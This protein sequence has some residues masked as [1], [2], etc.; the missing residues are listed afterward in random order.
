[1]LL[2]YLVKFNDTKNTKVEFEI[3][4]KIEFLL[5]TVIAL[6]IGLDYFLKRKHKDTSK[7]I[8][9][10]V[11]SKSKPIKKY[12]K[13]KW[14]L[15]SI[16]VIAV[17]SFLLYQFKFAP[18]TY[19]SA[20]VV[21]NDNLAYLKSD[22]SLFNGKI[23]DSLARGLF[24]EGKKVGRH[25]FQFNYYQNSSNFYRAEG[26]FL[27][28]KYTG[29]WSFYYKNGQLK[30][31][32]SFKESSGTELDS[33]GIPNE[34]RV[35]L[36]RFWHNNGQLSSKLTYIDGKV[37]GMRRDWYDNGQLRIENNYVNGKVEGVFRNWWNNGKL[38]EEVDQINGQRQGKCRRWYDNAQLKEE[39]DY[40]DGLLDGDWRFWHNNGQLKAQ[41]SYNKSRGVELGATGI[42]NKMRE[43]L[44]LFWFDNGQLRFEQS[45]IDGKL[46]GRALSWHTNGQLEYERYFVND[47]MKRTK[48]WNYD[49]TPNYY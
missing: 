39:G 21:F 40:V 11:D 12:F 30:A 42:P 37:E 10:F 33:L 47:I 35:G 49:G 13:L 6:V 36:W 2:N 34:M 8:T 32:G 4:M 14:I 26:V 19:K 48:S 38:L 41:G 3:N 27:D 31:Q 24:V 23:N 18:V 9:K 7:E 25:K 17:S 28:N 45:Y 44:W 22:M 1:M 20:E 16:G 46:Q 15:V 43:G 29:E 5:I